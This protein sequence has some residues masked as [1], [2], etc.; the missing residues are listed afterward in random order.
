MLDIK[1]GIA[2]HF[3]DLLGLRKF[4][5]PELEVCEPQIKTTA[6]SKHHVYK[7]RGKD[8]LGEVDILRRFREFDQLRKVLYSRFLGLYIPPIPEKKNLVRIIT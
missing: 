2:S 7:V 5:Q 1:T 3:K 6:A 4:D 8:H